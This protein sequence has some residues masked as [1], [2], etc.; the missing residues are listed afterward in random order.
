[1]ST[2][3]GTG[4]RPTC[5][6]DCSIT[7]TRLADL[8]SLAAHCITVWWLQVP[9]NSS[10]CINC[11]MSFKGTIAARHSDIHHYHFEKGAYKDPVIDAI[12]SGMAHGKISRIFQEPCMQSALSASP[13]YHRKLMKLVVF[14]SSLNGPCW[15]DAKQV[16]CLICHSLRHGKMESIE[17][18]RQSRCRWNNKILVVF[19]IL[20]PS[21]P[22]TPVTCTH[23]INRRISDFTCSVW[24]WRLST[25]STRPHQT[26][27]AILLGY[28][29]HPGT[30][31][32][33]SPVFHLAPS[34]IIS[35]ET[36]DHSCYLSRN[37]IESGSPLLSFPFCTLPWP[38]SSTQVITAN[39]RRIYG[40]LTSYDPPHPLPPFPLP[41]LLIFFSKDATK[42][43][44]TSDLTV[45][46]NLIII[47][48]QIRNLNSK[49]FVSVSIT[50]N[51][52]FL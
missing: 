18:G 8:E 28:R 2:S 37:Q 33:S 27:P 48:K 30:A 47:H 52:F 12:A 23:P 9:E 22:P 25:W 32:K 51:F 15:E 10:S 13:L 21:P 24:R 7:R 3:A 34:P 26:L 17:R 19:C 11:K 6:D 40:V 20:S 39:L 5:H 36:V 38:R 31:L 45:H 4:A 50:F 41:Y 46:K 16:R 14:M 35:V 44:K 1:M 49:M 43:L 29:R 42:P